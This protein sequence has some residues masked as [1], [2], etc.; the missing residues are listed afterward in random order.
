MIL[1][2]VVKLPSQYFDVP[3]AFNIHI[4]PTVHIRKILFTTSYFR[5]YSEP[6]LRQ[7]I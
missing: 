1:M 7:K 2:P 5:N 6:T 3:D 4:V